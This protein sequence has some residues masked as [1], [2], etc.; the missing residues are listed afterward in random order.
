M[1]ERNPIV[2][3]AAGKG[4]R[5][6]ADAVVPE[7]EKEEAATRPKASSHRPRRRPLLHHLVA[8]CVEED[9]TYAWSWRKTM[10]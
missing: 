3:M 6:K 7:W 9:V 4:S 2:I 1:T 5:M 10:R 8:Q